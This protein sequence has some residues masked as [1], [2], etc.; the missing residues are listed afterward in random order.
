MGEQ[1][2]LRRGSTGWFRVVTQDPTPIDE[3]GQPAD[4]DVN[5][6]TR[7]LVVSPEFL[8]GGGGH[9]NFMIALHT[10]P[11]DEPP[12]AGEKSVGVNLNHAQLRELRQAIT[13]FLE[14]R[15]LIG[16]LQEIAEDTRG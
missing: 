7:V 14:P 11:L 9:M 12:I 8:S 15:D 4:I 5:V 10:N 1:I 2:E 6:Y 16:E 13:D 3:N